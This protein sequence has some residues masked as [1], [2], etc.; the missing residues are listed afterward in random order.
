MKITTYTLSGTSGWRWRGHGGALGSGSPT[1]PMNFF[2]RQ[3][4]GIVVWQYGDH[5]RS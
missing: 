4:F 5:R 2:C 1:L 3:L